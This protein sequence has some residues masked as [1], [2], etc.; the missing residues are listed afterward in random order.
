MK[1]NTIGGE[2]EVITFEK[3]L[4]KMT[5]FSGHDGEKLKEFNSLISVGIYGES[6]EI[7]GEETCTY[8]RYITP[9]CD[10]IDGLR[11]TVL[12]QCSVHHAYMKD[13]RGVAEG[14]LIKHINQYGE[15]EYLVQMAPRLYMVASTKDW[16]V[17][18]D[19]QGS[20]RAICGLARF[21]NILLNVYRMTEKQRDEIA[22]KIME[23]R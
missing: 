5:H 17:Y 22:K 15:P 10:S 4:Q 8:A 12:N 7:E 19:S 13:I 9:Y 6:I 20:K 11:N 14:I 16:L 23:E 3:F 18:M 2:I 21:R 1:T